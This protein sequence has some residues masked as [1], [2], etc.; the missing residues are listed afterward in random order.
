[1]NEVGARV[2]WKE[3]MG[4]IRERHDHGDILSGHA[5]LKNLGVTPE[6]ELVLVV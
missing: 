6:L 3:F 2:Q 5:A 1:M 4:V